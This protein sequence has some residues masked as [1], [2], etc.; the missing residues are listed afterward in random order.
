MQKILLLLAF[1]GLA[2]PA[3]NAQNVRRV[4]VFFTHGHTKS[5]LMNIKEELKAQDFTVEYTHMEFD[6][7]GHLTALRFTVTCPDGTEG[8]AGMAPVPEE[9]VF[10]FYYD[11]RPGAV[12]RFRAGEIKE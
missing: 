7:E 11:P 8:S 12:E 5:D 10:G 3:L 6:D 9:T 1:A 2:L 4:E